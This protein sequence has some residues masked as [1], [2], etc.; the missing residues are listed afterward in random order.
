VQDLEKA[1]AYQQEQIAKHKTCLLG[2]ALIDLKLIDQAT[3]DSAVTEQLFNCAQHCKPPIG[4]LNFASGADSRTAGGITT[5][6]RAESDEGKFRGQR[7]A[8]IAYP[9]T[10]SR[11]SRIDGH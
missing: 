7:F 4:T 3:L 11:L 6:E 2:Q 10:T 9:L 1:L 8:R 5:P